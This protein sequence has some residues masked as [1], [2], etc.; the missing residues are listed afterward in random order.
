M[1]ECA[2]SP[3]KGT[4]SVMINIGVSLGVDVHFCCDLK[5]VFIPA[6]SPPQFPVSENGNPPRRTSRS[7]HE[8]LH[9]SLTLILG[10]RVY[11]RESVCRKNILNIDQ[12]FAYLGSTVAG[13]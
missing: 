9:A 11:T 12:I 13:I 4:S 3:S 5:L 7:H 6:V 8:R 1:F 2:K 10:G